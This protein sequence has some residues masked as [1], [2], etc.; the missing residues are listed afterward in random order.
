MRMRR[1]DHAEE[2]RRVYRTHVRAVYAFFA[3]SVDAASAEDLTSATFERV[4][5]AW[6]SFDPDRG[7]ERTWILS[8]AR[9][10]LTD[11]FRREGL[12]KTVSTDQHPALLDALVSTDDP[13]AG[14][15]STDRITEWLR[16]LSER[17]QEVL[18]LRFGADLDASRIA[19]LTGLSVENVHQISSRAVR[20]L[21]KVVEATDASRSA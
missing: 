21:R 1:R 11:H 4:V 19:A 10:A 7:G 14:R 6:D 18:A 9:N 2:V 12:R 13:L 15:L 16:A 8:I 17:E 5:R 3:Y 20:K